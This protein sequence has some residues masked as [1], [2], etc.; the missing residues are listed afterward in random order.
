MAGG[1]VWQREDLHVV[2]QLNAEWGELVHTTAP[3]VDEWAKRYP[4]FGGCRHL[5]DVL[6]AIRSNP[7]QA[8]AALIAAGA[9]GDQ[10]AHRTV[11]QSMLGKIVRLAM[12]DQAASI[13]DYV[14]AIWLRVRTYPLH[15]RPHRIAANLALDTFKAVKNEQARQLGPFHLVTMAPEEISQLGECFLTPLRQATIDTEGPS[16]DTLIAKAEG[17]RLIDEVTRKVLL[18]VYAEG[19]SGRRAA[20][21]H[22]TSPEMVR[23]R[24]SRA[25]RKMAEHR[26]LLAA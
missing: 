20:E 11:L 15:T 18:S 26:E 9:G 3:H 17:L 4:C 12:S 13:G 10:L 23:Y 25:V 6:S 1:R 21:R 7:D 19:L 22:K 5:D 14:S 8:L 2:D 16:A 24:C